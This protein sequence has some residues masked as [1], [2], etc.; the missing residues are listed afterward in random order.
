MKPE[1]V[2]VVVIGDYRRQHRDHAR[3]ARRPLPGAGALARGLPA[4]RAV[5]FDDEV[6]RIFAD[7]GLADEVAAISRPIPACG[8]PTPSTGCWPS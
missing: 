2:P 5:H 7:M 1:H 3:P 8:S 6:F 4:A